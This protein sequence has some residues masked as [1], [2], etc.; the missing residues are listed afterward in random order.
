MEAAITHDS[1]SSSNSVCLYFFFHACN[2]SGR[3]LAVLCIPIAFR[4][5]NSDFRRLRSSVS[6]CLFVV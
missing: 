4:S 2:Q 1:S 6:Y 5:V 3:C